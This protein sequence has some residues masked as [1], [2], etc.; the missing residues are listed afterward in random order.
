M[1]CGVLNDIFS[2]RAIYVLAYYTDID[3][4]EVAN[5]CQIWKP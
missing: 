2:G 3:S 5:N 4:V 1:T